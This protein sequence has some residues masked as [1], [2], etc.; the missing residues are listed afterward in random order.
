MLFW[1]CLHEWEDVRVMY[2][3]QREEGKDENQR[4]GKE[5]N[6]KGPKVV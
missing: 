3:L 1:D 4:V 5:G 2:V 6:V